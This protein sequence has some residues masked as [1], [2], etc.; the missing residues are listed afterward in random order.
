MTWNIENEAGHVKSKAGL[1]QKKAGR[2]GALLDKKFG[3]K[4]LDYGVVIWEDRIDYLGI[5]LFGIK[6]DDTRVSR[7]GSYRYM[8]SRD[9]RLVANAG[10]TQGERDDAG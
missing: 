1:I 2:M 6:W 9:R 8:A 4:V 5:I 3:S 10:S 7:T